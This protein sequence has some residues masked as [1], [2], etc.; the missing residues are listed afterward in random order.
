[1]PAMEPVRAARRAEESE[2]EYGTG[3][4]DD[5]ELCPPGCGLCCGVFVA[6]IAVAGY[7]LMPPAQPGKWHR[8]TTL[9]NDEAIRIVMWPEDERY[10]MAGPNDRA[11][12]WAVFYFKPCHKLPFWAEATVL[13]AT[14][15][16]PPLAAWRSRRDGEGARACVVTPPPG[17]CATGLPRYHAR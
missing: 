3:I 14:S 11:T 17:R 13:T 10:V 16:L 15:S 4:D 7:F 8:V 1:M 12:D 2:R 9:Q 5:D 6:I